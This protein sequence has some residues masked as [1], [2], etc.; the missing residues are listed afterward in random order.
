MVFSGGVRRSRGAA[1][2]EG[3]RAQ[4]NPPALLSH[5]LPPAMHHFDH[6]CT[7]TSD[8]GGDYS[9]RRLV[10]PG[11]VAE[12]E[13]VATEMQG[14]V[15]PKATPGAVWRRPTLTNARRSSRVSLA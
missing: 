2:F 7:L 4:L 5:P 6:R 8:T 3:G 15:R 13:V 1:G 14:P 11:I 9:S 10:R 12:G